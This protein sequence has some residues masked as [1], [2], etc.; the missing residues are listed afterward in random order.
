MNIGN[1]QAVSVV[2][3]VCKYVPAAWFDVRQRNA[4]K[5]WFRK[6]VLCKCHVQGT[7][8]DIIMIPYDSDGD[9]RHGIHSKDDNISR[10]RYR[11]CYTH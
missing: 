7:N 5:P 6:L 3:R 10:E 2:R 4:Q 8:F 11:D 9:T 1:E